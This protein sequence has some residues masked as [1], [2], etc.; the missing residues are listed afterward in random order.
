M[1]LRPPSTSPSPSPGPHDNGKA[2]ARQSMGP[3]S[4]GAQIMAPP[5]P[6]PGGQSSARPTSE[7]L[8]SGAMY[9]TPEA[10]LWTSGLKI[11]RITRRLW[12]VHI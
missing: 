4:R 5:S 3:P 6:R 11:S 10:E 9:Q 7:L 2:S 1:S 8:G 12:C